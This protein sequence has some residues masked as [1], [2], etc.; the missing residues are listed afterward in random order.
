MKL[1][2]DWSYEDEKFAVL[3]PETG[4]IKKSKK[5]PKEA[6][7]IYTEN[8]PAR[9][10]VEYLKLGI[11]VFRCHANK[12]AAL[13]EELKLEKT[14]ENDVKVIGELYSRS[15]E[16]FREWK[17]VP[18]ITNFYSLHKQFQKT[19][20]S[21][22]NRKWAFGDS[23]STVLDDSIKGLKDIEKKMLKECEKELSTY[24]IWSKWLTHI[25]GI[26]P[27]TASG[28]IGIIDN[29]G[30]ENF[31]YPS[32]LRKYFGLAPKNGKAMRRTKGETLGYNPTA[33]TL[34]MGLIAD[35]F[36]KSK[37]EYKRFYD[38]EK[39]RRLAMVFPEGELKEKCGKPYKKE[40]VG[41]SKGHASNMA[42]RKMMQI[43]LDHLWCIWRQL[44]GLSTKTPYAIDKLRHTGYIEPLYIP[45]ELMPFDPTSEGNGEI[46]VA[47][48]K[49]EP[50][51]VWG[52]PFF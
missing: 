33:K 25:R 15:P 47:R 34:A 1:F 44:E 14:D 2:V 30:I 48:I 36:I 16:D 31:D 35:S 4:K 21:V 3:N 12:V 26:G 43:F 9:I 52:N 37:S 10:G 17:G 45:E 41:Y 51:V 27:G 42:K 50:E 7:E 40:T 19:K 13:R 38:N 23:T 6:T 49:Y 32:R 11:K 20:V 28:L 5:L 22:M 24:D 29:I 8:M 46:H 39:E 18:H